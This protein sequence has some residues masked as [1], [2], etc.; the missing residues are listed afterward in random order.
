M[1]SFAVLVVVVV[2]VAVVVVA[3]EILI[4]VV[5]AELQTKMPFTAG[6]SLDSEGTN[7][8]QTFIHVKE[9]SVNDLYIHCD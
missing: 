7:N 6:F 3:A 2:V 1:L 5:V 8:T 4:V 9:I